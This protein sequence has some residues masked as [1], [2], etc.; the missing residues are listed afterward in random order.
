MRRAIRSP[1]VLGVT[2]VV[3]DGLDHD[4]DWGRW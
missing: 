2:M 3:R 4:F 1:M